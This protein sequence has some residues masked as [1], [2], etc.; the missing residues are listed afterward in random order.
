MIDIKLDVDNNGNLQL[1]VIHKDKCTSLEQKLLGS[2]IRDMWENGI[3]IKNPRG[4][5]V[6]G[7]DSWEV[8]TIKS[9]NG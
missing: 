5:L 3:E 2:L 4:G 6:T 8:Y 1:T 9:K 7:G